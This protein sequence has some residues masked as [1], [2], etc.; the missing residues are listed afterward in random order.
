[1]AD[2]AFDVLLETGLRVFPLP[3]SPTEFEDLSRFRNPALIEH[4]PREG[5]TL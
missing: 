4:I 3:L 5:K 2:I 1:M